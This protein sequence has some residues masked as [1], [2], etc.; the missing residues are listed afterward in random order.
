VNLLALQQAF[1]AA[2]VIGL[3]QL[4]VV[5]EFSVVYSVPVIVSDCIYPADPLHTSAIRL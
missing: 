2:L 3:G 4:V 1:L 5:P